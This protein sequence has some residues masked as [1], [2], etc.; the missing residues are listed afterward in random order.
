LISPVSRSRTARS[1]ARCRDC[2]PPRYAARASATHGPA[3]TASTPA[4]TPLPRP[5]GSLPITREIQ[6][7]SPGWP[8][9][10]L[11]TSSPCAEPR[12]P[13][14]APAWPAIRRR[15]VVSTCR[16]DPNAGATRCRLRVS[17]DA[18][19]GQVVIR[20]A[21]RTNDAACVCAVRRP[22]ASNGLPVPS[23]ARPHTRQGTILPRVGGSSATLLTQS[24]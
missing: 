1:R 2:L 10:D 11:A 18:T 17:P 12:K 19:T 3:A 6:C 5:Q 24:P 7:C 21:K 16:S 22:A 4:R 13:S 9:S 14:A 20:V 15:D 8:S 23:R